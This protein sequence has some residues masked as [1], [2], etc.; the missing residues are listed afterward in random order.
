MREWLP[1]YVNSV[2]SPGMV[3]YYGRMYYERMH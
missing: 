3:M 2:A 1:T